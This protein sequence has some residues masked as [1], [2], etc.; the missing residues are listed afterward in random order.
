MLQSCNTDLLMSVTLKSIDN[1]ASSASRKPPDLKTVVSPPCIAA[2]W[3]H[4]VR[5]C[6]TAELKRRKPSVTPG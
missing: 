4:H 2:G 6:L 1:I 5:L 3:F